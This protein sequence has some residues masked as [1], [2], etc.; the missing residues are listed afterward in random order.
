MEEEK[1]EAL[2]VA[3]RKRVKKSGKMAEHM[4]LRKEKKPQE[5]NWSIKGKLNYWGKGT[6]SKR[7]EKVELEEAAS[8]AKAP[9]PHSVSKSTSSEPF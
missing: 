8:E 2:V 3:S 9:S 7:R 6:E 1:A 4:K 5:D